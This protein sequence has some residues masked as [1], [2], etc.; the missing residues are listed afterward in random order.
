MHRLTLCI[1]EWSSTTPESPIGGEL[2][3]GMRLTDADRALA[4]ELEGRSS[5]R[6]TELR[7]GLAVAVGPHI[8]TVNLTALRIVIMPKLCIDNLMRM[9]AY[10][11]DLSD[12]IVTETETTY[13]S[14]EHGL[15]DLLGRTLLRAVE[16]LAR[17]G[18]LPEYQSR[19]EALTTPRGRLD[20]RYIATHPR[21]TALNCTYDDLTIDHALNQVLASGLRLAAAVM[22][23]SNLRLDLARLAD[24]VFGDLT[25]VGLD[26]DLLASLMGRLD[27][28]TGHYSTALTLVALIDQCA[29]LGEHGPA[30]D[31]PLSGFLLNMNLVF[32]R[33]L[34]RY[35][36][37][38][39]PGEMGIGTQDVR[40]DVFRYLANPSG[41]GRPTIRPDF[42]FWSP[43]RTIAVGDAKYKNRHEHPPTSAELYQLTTY[44]LAYAMP[45]PREVLLFHPLARG[46]IDRA[47][48]LLFAPAAVGQQVRIRLVGVPIDG[49]LD[50]SMGNWWPFSERDHLE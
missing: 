33:F 36:R 16:Y 40:G 49:L 39:A 12:L 22:E 14:A 41:W 26:A 48:T 44:G 8:G 31:M 13:S 38:H 21:R 46:E 47:S 45:E 29:H 3:R 35:F 50:G 11:F 15:I 43:R 6:F 1:R 34:G 42:V 7:S 27:R 32:E 4:G 10:A 30:G 19:R 5:L 9:V 17:G 18:L 23:S 37:E 24:R 2:L 20:L 25:R 28:R